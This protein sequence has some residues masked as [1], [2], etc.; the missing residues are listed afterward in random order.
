MVGLGGI[1]AANTVVADTLVVVVVVDTVMADTLVVVDMKPGMGREYLDMATVLYF[2]H[3]IGY[4]DWI[5]DILL[6]A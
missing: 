4:I 5:A 2:V 1:A 6:V 3:Y